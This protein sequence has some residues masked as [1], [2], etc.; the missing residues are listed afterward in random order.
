MKAQ[1]W[2]R[3]AELL[4][5]ARAGSQDAIWL[6]CQLL[7]SHAKRAIMMRL[8]KAGVPQQD[9]EDAYHD[10]LIRLVQRIWQ[11][12][13]VLCFA[14]WLRRIEREIA[15]K[16]RPLCTQRP[17]PTSAQIEA[18]QV[19]KEIEKK[20][21]TVNAQEEAI[22]VY[23]P[24]SIAEKPPRTLRLVELSDLT[25]TRLSGPNQ[26][27][28]PRKL[29]TWNAMATLPTR[30]ADALRLMVVEGRSAAEIAI[31]LGCSVP[32]VFRLVQLAKQ[33]M[34]ELLP[35]Y[36]QTTNAYSKSKSEI[37]DLH[38]TVENVRGVTVFAS[39]LHRYTNR[40]TPTK[41]A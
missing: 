8:W 12:Q 37:E 16:Y 38:P 4:E 23:A 40:L 20:Q 7:E 24:A 21:I 14:G 2:K 9:L 28:Y 36:S 32:R 30:W 6:A 22:R 29:D 11:L 3:L 19:A 41:A 10:V 17:I 13:N 33:R 15:G 27:N 1:E 39:A 25:V 35:G 26:A 5:Q 18:S 31:I 34:R